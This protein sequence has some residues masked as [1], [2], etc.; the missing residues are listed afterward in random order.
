MKPCVEGIRHATV[1]TSVQWD[2]VH[3]ALDAA[4]SSHSPYNLDREM[5][6]GDFALCK[7]RTWLS[8]TVYEYLQPRFKLTKTEQQLY[9]HLKQSD[10][11]RKER[12]CV[13]LGRRGPGEYIVCFLASFNFSPL[14][15]ELQ[16][17][18]ISEFMAIP[19]GDNH[20]GGLRWF[21]PWKSRSLIALPV[22]R[23]NLLPVYQRNRTV[24]QQ[25]AYGELERALQLVRAKQ[26]EFKANHQTLRHKELVFRSSSKTYGT[27]KHDYHHPNP[28]AI[29]RGRIS[30]L[31][32]HQNPL[33]RFS[34][35]TPPRTR[36]N[37]RWVL[38]HASQDIVEA[39]RYLSS[40]DNLPGPQ[41][42]LPPP[43]Y[44]S[45]LRA[46]AAFIRRRILR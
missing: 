29:V 41:F 17:A 39:S 33:S 7:D 24:R 25:L 10:V 37:I 26:A 32:H 21:P 27:F 11:E 9:E 2:T 13:V 31:L 19:C 16:D 18:P 30:R 38:E 6:P 42:H 23:T 4:A 3:A 34:Y 1:G 8:E 40:V 12:P 43:F 36:E 20:E 5:D 28:P 14:D 45:P 46:S 22:I 35:L 15:D 44:S